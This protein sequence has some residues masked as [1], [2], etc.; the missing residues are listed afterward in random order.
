LELSPVKVPETAET[1]TNCEDPY[2]VELIRRSV[3]LTWADRPVD[4]FT[5]LMAV[6]IEATVVP[7]AK[8]NCV[9]PR[10]PATC[11]VTVL[12]LTVPPV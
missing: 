4:P 8:D 1:L 12:P 7:E 6:A 9:V 10:L 3:P 5:P 2:A 11:S